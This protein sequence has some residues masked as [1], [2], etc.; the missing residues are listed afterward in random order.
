MLAKFDNPVSKE[1]HII[2]I[3]LDGALPTPRLTRSGEI[4]G[5]AKLF[6]KLLSSRGFKCVTIDVRA[7]SLTSGKNL[8]FAHLTLGYVVR[9]MRSCSS[10]RLNDSNIL[11][12]AEFGAVYRRQLEPTC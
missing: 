6:N 9:N 3:W 7:F 1:Y 8:R 5:K 11:I 4:S 2:Q 10:S 12:L